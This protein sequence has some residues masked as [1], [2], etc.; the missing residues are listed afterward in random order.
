[1]WGANMPVDRD[2]AE[3]LLQVQQERLFEE[4]GEHLPPATIGECL[5]R[6]LDRYSEARIKTFVPVLAYRDAR[7]QLRT[8]A[9]E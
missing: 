8:L 9:D 1:M 6:S 4:F 3:A 5:R 7:E 2:S